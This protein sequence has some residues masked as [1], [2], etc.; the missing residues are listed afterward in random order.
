MGALTGLRVVEMAGLGPVPFAA[1]ML[2]DMG[3]E[4]LRIDSPPRNPEDPH[5]RS[6]PIWR[7]RSGITVDLKDPE[8]VAQVK[9]II[10]VADVIIEGF[11]PGVME[12]LGLS[13]EVLLDLN[14]RLVYGRMT[15]WGQTGPLATEAGH[16]VNYLA[17]SGILRQIGREG[18]RPIPP[19]NLVGD[20]GGGGMLLT[21]GVLG[22]LVERAMSG[23]GQVIDAAMIDGAALLMVSIAGALARG[24][25]QDPPGTNAID[26]GAP[27]YEVYRT[28]DGRDLAFGAVE[29]RFYSRVLSVLELDP[30]LA[31]Q[32]YDRATWAATKELFAARVAERSLAEWT[33]A[34]DGADA[35]VSPVLTL[36]EAASHPHFA[37]RGT[38]AE[39]GGSVQPAAAP[40]FSRTPS[41]TTPL[42]GDTDPQVLLE[43]WHR[44]STV[45]DPEP[46]AAEQ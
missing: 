19:L 42:H 6:G 15:G 30:A 24:A 35:C 45:S 26:T 12:R 2:A 7:G 39:F 46:Q 43:R 38:W 4:V 37:E 32:Q 3:A 34:F 40:R 25:W 31:D 22:A 29:P 41:S 17:I 16:D 20:Y 21:V 5:D 33:K 10:A 8:G 28:A 44:R 36:Q 11:R 9:E 13:P 27:F 1:M 18:E 23:L 14:P